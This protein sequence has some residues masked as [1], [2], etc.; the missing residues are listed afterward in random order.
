MRFRPLI[1]HSYNGQPV[2]TYDCV[3]AA[4]KAARNTVNLRSGSRGERY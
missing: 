1:I 4:K 2:Y 3:S